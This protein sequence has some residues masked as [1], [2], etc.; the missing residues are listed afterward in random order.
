M[1]TSACYYASANNQA[2]GVVADTVAVVDNQFSVRNN[3]YIFTDQY[4]LVGAAALG[5]SLTAAQIDS[6]TIDATNP[7]QIYPLNA[8][9][10][11]WSTNPNILDLRDAPIQIPTNEE[12]KFQIAGGAGGAEADFG[13]LFLRYRG[14]GDITYPIMPGTLANPRFIAI[15]TVTLVHT[16]G[17][18]SAFG[19]MT[20]T[21]QLRGGAYKVNALQMI[22]AKAI[23][24]RVL[25]VKQPPVAG[26]RV[27]P[28]F[29]TDTTYGNVPFDR[30]PTWLG[31][32]G[33]FNQFELP[34]ISCFATATQ[35][36]ATYTGYA[37]LTYMG[38]TNADSMP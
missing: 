12:V 13:V 35:G 10:L 11:S 38:A 34:Q 33:I 26:R 28:C 8:A 24:G 25:F 16:I 6:P 14:P 15:F 20:F 23:L 29:L 18:W 31:G 9:A 3:H 4:E 27:Y 17:T 32:L 22:N 7:M 36:S 21:N 2:A 1:F 5:A 19:A 30:R 37:D